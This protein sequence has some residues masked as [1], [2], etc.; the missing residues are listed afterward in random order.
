[1]LV[2]QNHNSRCLAGVPMAVA[3]LLGLG[4][5]AASFAAFGEAQIIEEEQDLAKDEELIMR[6]GSMPTGVIPVLCANNPNLA[7]I[8]GPD[9]AIMRVINRGSGT[10]DERIDVLRHNNALFKTLTPTDMQMSVV[11][12]ED[13]DNIIFN[14]TISKEFLKNLLTVDPSDQEIGPYGVSI[15]GQLGEG[16][17]YW[18]CWYANSVKKCQCIKL[19]Q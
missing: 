11:E 5:M 2:K 8:C 19:Q 7:R 17:C 18:E 12:R 10:P 15:F 14:V 1:V 13:N 9:V 16:T 6:S 4:V 3:L